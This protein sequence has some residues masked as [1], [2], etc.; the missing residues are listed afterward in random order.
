MTSMTGVYGFGNHPDGLVQSIT[1]HPSLG[2]ELVYYVQEFSVLW[3]AV[4]REGGHPLIIFKYF[5][6]TRVSAMIIL[7]DCK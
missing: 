6:V 5:M 7:Q 3:V 1:S 4:K 2:Q